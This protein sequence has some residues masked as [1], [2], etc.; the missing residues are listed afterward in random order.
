MSTKIP[1]SWKKF[2]YRGVPLEELMAMPLEKFMELLPARARRS[3][4]K[5]FTPEQRVLLNKLR[6]YPKKEIRTHVRDMIILPEMVG[7]RIA[8]HNGKEFVS[9][10]INPLMIGHYLGEFAITNVPVKHSGIG[11]G[12]T[13]STKF[14]SKK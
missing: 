5:D 8:V 13:R 9:I 4:K 10:R 2:R 14:L 12:G 1:S 11:K 6:R 7:R 3:L